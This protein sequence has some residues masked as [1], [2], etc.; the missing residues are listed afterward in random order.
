MNENPSE[1]QAFDADLR[2]RTFFMASD[3]PP[4]APKG[5]VQGTSSEK[6]NATLLP[7]DKGSAVF[8]APPS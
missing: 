1:R 2:N 7:A 8:Q 6:Y 5:A 3:P 4:H